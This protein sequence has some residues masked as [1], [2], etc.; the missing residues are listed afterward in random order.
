MKLSLLALAMLGTLLI[1]IRTGFSIT[2]LPINPPI[3]FNR[4]TSD[5]LLTVD[6]SSQASN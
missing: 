4:G 6:D 1:P 2:T 5:N 3:D